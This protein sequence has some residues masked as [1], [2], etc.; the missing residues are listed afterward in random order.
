MI[1]LSF[2]GGPFGGG[3]GMGIISS[4]SLEPGDIRR[5][6]MAKREEELRKAADKK[7]KEERR[8]ALALKDIERK[9]RFS[10]IEQTTEKLGRSFGQFG[11]VPS[12]Q[13]LDLS[14]CA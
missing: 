14:Y 9:K 13:R 12:S 2:A 4:D 7:R 6:Q 1:P 5:F 3:G 11:R 10:R 8:K